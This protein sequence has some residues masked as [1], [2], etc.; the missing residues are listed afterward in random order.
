MVPPSGKKN[1]SVVTQN[2][3]DG[4][5]IKVDPIGGPKASPFENNKFRSNGLILHSYPTLTADKKYATLIKISHSR[6]W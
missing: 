2:F 1:L 4:R 3:K 5:I 6:H